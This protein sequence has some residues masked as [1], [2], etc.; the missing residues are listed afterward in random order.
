MILP[1]SDSQVTRITGMSHWHPENLSF[2]DP[3]FESHKRERN[4]TAER[5][6]QT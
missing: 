3:S 1:I 2:L 6:F 4:L 5:K